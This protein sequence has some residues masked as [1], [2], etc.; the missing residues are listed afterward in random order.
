MCNTHFEDYDLQTFCTQNYDR[1]QLELN[2][3][4]V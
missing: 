2:T 3:L 1:K 4:W